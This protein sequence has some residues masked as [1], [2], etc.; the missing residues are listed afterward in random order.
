MEKVLVFGTGKR[1]MRVIEYLE[2]SENEL[3][4]LIDNNEEKQGTYYNKVEIVS[5]QEINQYMYDRILICS[6]YYADIYRQLVEEIHVPE[7]K[8]TD[9]TYFIKKNLLNYYD[10]HREEVNEDMKDSIEYIKNFR[11]GV[12]NDPFIEKYDKMDFDV[13]YDLKKQLYFVMSNGKKMYMS[14]VY[15][16]EQKVREYY[17]SIIVEQDKCSPHRYIDEKFQ[18]E[19]NSVVIDAGVAEGNFALD[20]ID[21]VKKI[22]L[23]EMD[24][25][26]IEALKFTFEPYKEKVQIIN[27]FLSS[28]NENGNITIDEIA[29]EEHINFIKLDIEGE[30]ILALQGA[31]QFLN[32]NSNIKLDICSYHNHD[33]EKNIK[34]LLTEYGFKAWTTAG[35]MVFMS[36]NIEPKKLVRGLVRAEK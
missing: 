6:V 12:F 26:W 20:V 16:T 34:A 13:K 5:P 8:I 1:A 23:V 7:N 30:E 32:N 27:Q 24:E 14:S 4:A 25:N 35:Y 2:S 28:N 17:K 15:N 33:D 18:V 31:K 9:H 11:L 19:P 21:I 36:S 29:K 10:T 22:Y 3:L